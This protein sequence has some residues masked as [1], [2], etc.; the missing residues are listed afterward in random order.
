MSIEV[1]TQTI[2]YS[3]IETLVL[4]LHIRF[5]VF[6][7]QL[8]IDEL[9]NDRSPFKNLRTVSRDDNWIRKSCTGK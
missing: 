4:L 1:I 2:P 6:S 8:T 5:T 3:P 7:I 9:L